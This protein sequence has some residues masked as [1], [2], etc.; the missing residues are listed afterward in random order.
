MSWSIFLGNIWGVVLIEDFTIFMSFCFS[1]FYF[2]FIVADL[3]LFSFIVYNS[4]LFVLSDRIILLTGVYW[5]ELVSF[6]QFIITIVVVSLVPSN[7]S[8]LEEQCRVL[9]VSNN[10][11]CHNFHSSTWLRCIASRHAIMRPSN[12]KW[13][14]MMS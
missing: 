2:T 12:F 10:M 11:I 7:Y 8:Y 1:P 14:W 13:I 3:L 4:R 5:F 6:P 9:N